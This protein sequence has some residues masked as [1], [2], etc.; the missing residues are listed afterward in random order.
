MFGI[1]GLAVVPYASLAGNR[2]EASLSDSASS[3]AALPY[4]LKY[5]HCFVGAGT[6]SVNSWGEYAWGLNA[7]ADMQASDTTEG[8]SPINT[9]ITAVSLASDDQVPANYIPRSIDQ[10]LTARD[11]QLGWG[12]GGWSGITGTYPYTGWGESRVDAFDAALSVSASL[13][14]NVT[15][16]ETSDASAIFVTA[17]S[18]S[19]DAADVFAGVQTFVC[20]T[21]DSSTISDLL[22]AGVVFGGVFADTATGDDTEAGAVTF[23]SNTSDTTSGSD[24]YAAAADFIA[25]MEDQAS[26]AANFVARVAF[27][28][29]VLESGTAIDAVTARF[30]WELIDDS[31]TVSWQNV[32]SSES[33]SWG[34]V[35][36]AQ[37]AAWGTIDTSGD[38][39]WGNVDTSE[40]T[41]WSNIDTSGLN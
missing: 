41:D 19:V 24:S 12:A 14:D 1:S 22:A 29:S 8:R 21:A 10:S 26:A 3:S 25:S 30:L 9:F 23:V 28:A 4:A 35:Q 27:I 40:S 11:T 34:N 6:W 16:S 36:T 20:D 38:G 13:S 31:Q 17:L 5:K 39:G 33:T 7:P 2:Y 18:D 37:T 32:D 15:P